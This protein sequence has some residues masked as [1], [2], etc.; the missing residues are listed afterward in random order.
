M[1]HLRIDQIDLYPK[2]AMYVTISQPQLFIK[3]NWKA[4]NAI[5]VYKSASHYPNDALTQAFGPNIAI[6]SCRPLG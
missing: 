6:N 3:G 1:F 5:K 4:T 2:M